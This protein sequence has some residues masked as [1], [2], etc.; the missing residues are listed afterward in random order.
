MGTLPSV[1]HAT[2]S[3]GVTVKF[4]GI[5][6][7]KHGC[8]CKEYEVFG[9][10][11]HGNGLQPFCLA[12]KKMRLRLTRSMNVASSSH[13][14]DCKWEQEVPEH[15]DGDNNKAKED[16]KSLSEANKQKE[17]DVVETV[18]LVRCAPAAES[19]P[20]TVVEEMEEI[21]LRLGFGQTVAM[22][23]VDDQGIDS[24]WSLSDENITTI[25][26]MM[27]KP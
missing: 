11:L 23:V 16:K 25:W 9:A 8:C 12:G 26:D 17:E 21:I 10:V 3:S 2:N 1:E 22:K 7:N 4:I 15:P 20:P 5:N 27:Q 14:G 13:G 19:L 24:P 18:P 6:I